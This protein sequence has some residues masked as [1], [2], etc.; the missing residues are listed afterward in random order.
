MKVIKRKYSKVEVTNIYQDFS[1]FQTIN[2]APYQVL[3]VTSLSST[4]LQADL[5]PE[6]PIGLVSLT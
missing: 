2:L 1:Y 4:I 6:V 3:K 5:S